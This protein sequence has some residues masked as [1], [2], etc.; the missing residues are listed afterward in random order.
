MRDTTRT[1]RD[2]ARLGW[3][4]FPLRLILGVTF[5]YGG[6]Q[7]FSDPGFFH[8]GAPTYIGTQLRGFANGTP[9][10]FLLR[11]FAI[12]Q[13]SLAGPGVAL[14][15][16]AVG[17]LVPPP[18]SGGR[19]AEEARV[20][21]GQVIPKGAIGARVEPYE[22]GPLT[23]TLDLS[24]NGSWYVPSPVT[25]TLDLS[26]AGS[27]YVPAPVTATLDLSAMGN[28]IEWD[29]VPGRAPQPAPRPR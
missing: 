18:S 10:G 5:V 22:P 11:A 21:V 4:L 16:I 1:E 28:W 20:V 29:Q 6:I 15:E 8:P 2:A 23:V 24:A 14:N 12:P 26:A 25:A 27:W 13:P 9:G 7:K 19:N 3:S 17:L